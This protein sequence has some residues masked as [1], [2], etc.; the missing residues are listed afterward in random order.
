[1]TTLLTIPMKIAPRLDEAYNAWSP[2]RFEECIVHCL[3][4]FQLAV[5]CPLQGDFILTSVGVS[6]ILPHIQELNVSFATEQK[7]DK[8]SLAALAKLK[9]EVE[10][11]MYLRESKPQLLSDA[12]GY[13]TDMLESAVG[14]RLCIT[15]PSHMQAMLGWGGIHT[16]LSF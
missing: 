7:I 3:S 1:M 2:T 11:L 9:I 15:N 8:L 6:A 10:D 12:V 14:K 13:A 4:Y 16:F 5:T